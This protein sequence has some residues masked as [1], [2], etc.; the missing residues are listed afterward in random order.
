MVTT[1]HLHRLE[2]NRW[3]TAN[4]TGLHVCDTTWFRNGRERVVETVVGPKLVQLRQAQQHNINVTFAYVLG[5]EHTGHHLWESLY[6][7]TRANSAASWLI[8]YEVGFARGRIR[9]GDGESCELDLAVHLALEERAARLAAG[10]GSV[11]LGI[12]SCSY[13]CGPGPPK[14][15]VLRSP[16]AP[17][18]VRAAQRAGTTLRLLVTLR[19]SEDLFHGYPDDGSDGF[20]NASAHVVPLGDACELMLGQLRSI[21]SIRA[22]GDDLVDV[23]FVHYYRTAAVAS[24]LSEF[25][26]FDVSTAIAARFRPSSHNSPERIAERLKLEQRGLKA[27]AA[28]Q[29]LASCNK[30]LHAMA[31]G[32]DARVA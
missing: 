26:R 31:D 7:S 25:L 22:H 14:F 15:N 30:E 3:S 19:R 2:P 28:W 20:A 17:L 12:N 23:L 13:P 16:D 29:K 11:L 4:A 1:Q 8:N 27:S 32:Q 24:R 5:L 10:T 9:Q 21:A 6:P 18:L